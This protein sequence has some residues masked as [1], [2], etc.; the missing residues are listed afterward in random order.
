MHARARAG[1]EDY[2]YDN[3]NNNSSS[4][5]SS[6][7]KSSNKKGG[8][9]SSSSMSGSTKGGSPPDMRA[10]R[11]QMAEM[12]ANFEQQLEQERLEKKRIAEELQE[13]RL[14]NMVV[15]TGTPTY[16]SLSSKAARTPTPAT[17]AGAGSVADSAT[18]DKAAAGANAIP[19]ASDGGDTA[20]TAVRQ[21]VPPEQGV[22]PTKSQQ[23]KKLFGLF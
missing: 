3:N 12:K 14:K 23:R 13:E 10:I 17:A 2:N 22:P 19:R 15:D 18:I 1:S 6:S 4:S 7:S 16:K 5:S 20:D 21:P 11:D 9:S 8:N